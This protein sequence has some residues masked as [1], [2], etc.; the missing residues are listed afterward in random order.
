MF[1]AE[2]GDYLRTTGPSVEAGSGVDLA[3]YEGPHGVVTLRIRQ[4]ASEQ[5]E[6]AVNTLPSGATGVGYDPGIG[7][8][9]GVFFSYGGEFHAAWA[10][11]DWVFV[12]SASTDTARRAFI[13]AYGF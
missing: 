3:S 10:N 7:S 5:V 11:Q 8:R 12:I 13:A 2:V 4:V 1:P 9:D 6:A